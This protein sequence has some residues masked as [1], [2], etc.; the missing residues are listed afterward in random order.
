MARLPLARKIEVSVRL[1]ENI[2]GSIG[3]RQF[4]PVYLENDMAIPLFKE[5]GAITGTAK[6]DGFIVVPENID[7]IREGE[8][9]TVIL[10]NDIV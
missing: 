9:A 5:S 8:V 7:M 3:R 10:F 1:A 2:S 4:L 6:A